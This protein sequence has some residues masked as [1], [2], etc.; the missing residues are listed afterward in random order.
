VLSIQSCQM[1]GHVSV[2]VLRNIYVISPALFH[3]CIHASK[4]RSC[5][6][7]GAPVQ[8]SLR[9]CVAFSNVCTRVIYVMYLHVTK[10]QF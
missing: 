7:Y 3:I 10:S 5:T 1:V 8:L 2:Y 4:G 9:I 6:C